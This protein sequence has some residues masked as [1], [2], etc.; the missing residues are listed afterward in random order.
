[1]ETK[2]PTITYL[3]ITSKHYWF[4]DE[5]FPELQAAGGE[6]EEGAGAEERPGSGETEERPGAAFPKAFERELVTPT[7]SQVIN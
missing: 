2:L 7:P 3:V 4:Q 1:M 5:T 6:P